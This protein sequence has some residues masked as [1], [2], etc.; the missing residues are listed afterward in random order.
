MKRYLS[1]LLATIVLILCCADEEP[2]VVNIIYPLDNSVV[3]D[4]VLIEASA[5]DNREV[6]RVEFYLSDSLIGVTEYMPFMHLLITEDMPDSSFYSLYAKAYDRAGN[7][8]VSPV[9]KFF[10]FDNLPPGR[11]SVPAGPSVGYI[12][13][14]YKFST[15]S[16]D[17]DSDSV[18]IRFSWG[19][20]DTSI[21][22][23]FVSSGQAVIDSHK[24]SRPADYLVKAQARDRMGWI[25]DWSNGSII[26]IV[27]IEGNCKWHRRIG[28]NLTSSPA[29]SDIVLIGSD[30]GYL[31]ALNPDSTLRWRFFAGSPIASSPA[32][33]NDGTIYIGADNGNLY[34]IGSNGLI[35]WSYPT[36]GAIKST[37]A[38][39][40]DGSIYFGSGDGCLYGLRPDGTRKW[41][42]QTTGPIVASP[43][44]DFEGSVYI[45]STDG[46]F[47]GVDTA[48][49]EKWRYRTGGPILNSAAISADGTLYF[50]SDDNNLYA[51]DTS[52]AFRWQFAT[53]GAIRSAPIIGEED[54]IYFG[55]SDCHLYSLTSGGLLRWRYPTGGP[56]NSTPLCS[57]QGAIYFGSNDKSF[58]SL[59]T[60]GAL[61]WRFP[62]DGAIESSS[63]L[64]DD[65]TIYFSSMDGHL[66]SVQ[67]SGSI[68]FSN[69]PM[70]QHDLNHTGRARLVR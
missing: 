62:T 33:A 46:Y 38:L 36:G 40:I 57:F 68:I 58:Y 47:Y 28:A 60:A 15:V 29:V 34:A 66:Y 44:I 17:P 59:N 19:D 22:H 53:S 27:L 41:I 50:G 56:V 51:L 5:T 63:A 1:I 11:P 61:R 12:D 8:G 64:V 70:F 21:W 49:Q 31:Y 9:V 30:D 14:F 25:S 7:E 20:G 10:V 67:A 4:T 18:A 16:I 37:P 23:P 26:R 3:S 13:S 69:W 48:G 2:P 6:A 35:K 45:G 39:A 55:S 54:N 32:I 42:F 65:G 52:G 24:W 43:V